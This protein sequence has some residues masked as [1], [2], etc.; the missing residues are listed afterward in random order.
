MLLLRKP[1]QSFHPDL[2]LQVFLQILVNNY[3]NIQWEQINEC[4]FG[5]YSGK[6]LRILNT[7][8]VI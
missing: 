7:N 4:K 3:K 5:D 2:M 8:P 6:N 1:Q